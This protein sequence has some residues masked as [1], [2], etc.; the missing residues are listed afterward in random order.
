MAFF[1]SDSRATPLV[2]S[3]MSEAMRRRLGELI[4]LAW[5][6]L[7]VLLG[8][9]LASYDIADPSPFSS[10]GAPPSN[11]LGR[12]GAFVAG[13]PKNSRPEAQTP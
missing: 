7:A 10:T 8:L 11:W 9:C 6:A 1:S 13:G 12:A 5:G 2:D 3:E 4:G